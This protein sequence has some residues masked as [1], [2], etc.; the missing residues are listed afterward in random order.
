MSTPAAPVT[1]KPAA[2][3]NPARVNRRH[4]QYHAP[5]VMR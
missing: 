2:T 3:H 4:V 1:M 5:D